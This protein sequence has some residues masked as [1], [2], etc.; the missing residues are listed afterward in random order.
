MSRDVRCCVTACFTVGD[1]WRKVNTGRGE[2]ESASSTSGGYARECLKSLRRFG[3]VPTQESPRGSFYHPSGFLSDANGSTT[4]LFW[5]IN[6]DLI[7]QL[8]KIENLLF[9]PPLPA[10]SDVFCLCRFGVFSHPASTLLL[11]TLPSEL[12]GHQDGILCPFL[13]SL[14]L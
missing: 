7:E 14:Q 12:L 1:G 13:F 10:I 11:P 3:D 5:F 6:G 2:N 9:I 4:A 8:P